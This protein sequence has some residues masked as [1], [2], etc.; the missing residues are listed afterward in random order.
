MM[1]E[2]LSASRKAQVLPRRVVD[3]L[4][5]HRCSAAELAHACDVVAGH[6]V[7]PEIRCSI[8]ERKLCLCG[9]SGSG[10]RIAKVETRRS[11]WLQTLIGA[12]YTDY[13]VACP[14]QQVKSGTSH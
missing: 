1:S 9:L 8:L 2:S 3:G 4:V 10:L 6:D 7:L 13:G 14:F 12:V 11:T 5:A